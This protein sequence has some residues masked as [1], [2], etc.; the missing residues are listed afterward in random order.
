MKKIFISLLTFCV[1]N[2][3]AL[4]TNKFIN[5]KVS[6]VILYLNGAELTQKT[7]VTLNKGNNSIKLTG[8]A[9]TIDS[10][11]IRITSENGVKITSISYEKNYLSEEIN[12]K[13]VKSLQDSIKA[14]TALITDLNN[15]ISSLEEEKELLLKNKS[16]GGQ[17]TGVSALELQK[18]ADFFRIRLKD[19]NTLKT[20][21]GSKVT[22]LEEKITKLNKQLNELNNNE[23]QPEYYVLVTL[24]SATQTTATLT[25]KYLV[26][27]TGWIPYYDLRTQDVNSPISIEYKAN[28][29]NN[30]GIDWN[31]INLTLSTAN[32]Q[33]SSQKPSLN[34]WYL[35]Y[36]TNIYDY[37]RS[38]SISNIMPGVAVKSAQGLLDEV[39]TVGYSVEKK[40]KDEYQFTNVSESAL[41]VEFEIK[42]KYS[43]PADN[44]I[45]SADIQT[46]ELSA[47]YTYFAVPKLDKDAFLVASVT[48]WESLNLLDGEANI[49]YGNSYVGK[50]VISTRFAKDTL[51]LSLGRDKKV[52]ITRIKKEDFSS[53]KFLGSDIKQM[54][55]YEISVRNN[56][57]TAIDIEIQD[58]IPISQNSEIKVNAVETS[59]VKADDDT[60]LLKYNFTLKP[61]ENKIIKISY[62]VQYPKDKNI[63]F[64]PTM[65]TSTN[66]RF[67]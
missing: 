31:N 52:A 11:S 28:I 5:T 36:L 46:S 26:S 66:A 51:M 13:E 60:G 62:S 10:K 54:F 49:Y 65:P 25:L 20:K 43:L 30:S 27:D 17:N 21:F 8:I 3:S 14:N 55:T 35:N 58:Q 2:V 39:V 42:D 50:S 1:L 63:Q 34:P 37:G 12:N 4:E 9:K 48:G 41:S 23:N 44:K 33:L 40:S 64:N 56:N 15:E 18:M 19:I 16:I 53:K 57:K 38:N 47:K 6:S 67:R 29:Y 7:D 45:Y 61:L 24:N 59:G 32:P 22:A